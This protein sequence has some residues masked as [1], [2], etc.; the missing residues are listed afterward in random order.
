MS[1]DGAINRLNQVVF[2]NTNQNN[3][4]HPASVQILNQECFMN[5][6]GNI[7]FDALIPVDMAAKAEQIGI[8][9]AQMSLISTF[10]L[11]ILAG[12]FISLGAV[13]ATTVVAG[14]SE[15]IPYGVRQVLAGLVFSLGLSWSLWV[16]RNFSPVTP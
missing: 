10:V 4:T 15:V 7:Q 14:S 8:K 12:A 6:N 11:A 13:F 3:D 2:V 1:R 16:G 5:T 9:K